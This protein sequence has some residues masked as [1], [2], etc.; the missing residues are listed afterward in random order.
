MTGRLIVLG[1]VA[2]AVA[3]IGTTMDPGMTPRFV[4]NAS[5]ALRS[6]STACTRR[7]I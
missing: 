5:E 4:W 1:T 7:T 3:A 2:M 6:G